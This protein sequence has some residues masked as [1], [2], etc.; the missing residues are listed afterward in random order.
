[1]AAAQENANAFF[2]YAQ[3]AVEA[4]PRPSPYDNVLS[5]VAYRLE[6]RVGSN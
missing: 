1:M 4:G 5:Y 6:V 2:E 3:D